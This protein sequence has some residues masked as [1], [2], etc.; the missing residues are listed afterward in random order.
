MHGG[1]WLKNVK[2]EEIAHIFIKTNNKT[3]FFS[4]YMWI[5]TFL[6]WSTTAMWLFLDDTIT[7]DFSFDYLYFRFL[8]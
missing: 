6:E 3:P 7:S 5:K 4:L 1:F 2:N 8:K